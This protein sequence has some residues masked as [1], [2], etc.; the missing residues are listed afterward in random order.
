MS[1]TVSVK[2]GLSN[3]VSTGSPI[4][5]TNRH[6][7]VTVIVPAYNEETV[8]EH[9]LSSLRQQTE[10]L[11]VIVVDD[12]SSDNTGEVAKSYKGVAV[13][14]PPS[15]TG[16]KAGAQNYALP[17]INTRYTIALDA[18]TSLAKDAIQ[19]MVEFME[20]HPEAVA[21]CSFVLPKKI[22]TIW[23]RGR[24]IEY[25]YAFT[26]YKRIQ[27]WYAKPLIS[28]GCFSIYGT[29]ELK[30]VGGWS[31]RTMAEDMDLTW[32][33]YEKGK[34]VR[35]NHEAFCF[36]LEPES[37]TMM[38]KQLTRWSH[39]WVQNLRLHW[40][41]IRKIPVLREIVVAQI[42][43]ALFGGVIYLLTFL[44]LILFHNL[45]LLIFLLISETTLVV[46]PPILKGIKLKMVRKVLS[47]LPC[48][49][50]VRT[51]NVYYIYRAYISELLLKKTLTKY[52]KGH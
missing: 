12:F 24:F 42:S 44:T 14:R 36:P 30:A 47:S 8:I 18:D 25:M 34:V 11:E 21:T 31:T 43:D 10:L 37:F 46:L 23:E 28:S 9:T 22:N 32:T 27:E 41:N 6:A 17:F 19:K 50:I 35:Y 7:L 5:T 1:Q 15:N 29:D 48:Y 26:F 39:G 20:S 45:S 40:K 52:E 13:I 2:N 16:S 49:Y 38:S 33:F 51:V 4:F 3:R